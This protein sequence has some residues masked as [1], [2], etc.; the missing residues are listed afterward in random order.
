MRGIVLAATAIILGLAAR[1]ASAQG[2]EG[3]LV[4]RYHAAPGNT[5][6][7][8]PMVTYRIFLDLSPGHE[9]VSVFGERGRNL[10]FRT[11]TRF[12]NDTVNGAGGGERI[13]PELLRSYPAAIDSW[14]AFGFAT[15]RHKAVPLPLDQDGSL[16]APP[17]KRARGAW[18]GPE[19]HAADGLAPAARVPEVLLLHI[20][21]S[22]LEKLSGQLIETEVGAYGV[23]GTVK[24][25]TEENMVLIAQLTTDGELS[26][27]I[28]AAV[29]APDGTIT[30]HLA[31]PALASDEVEVP[32][33]RRGTAF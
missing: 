10:F 6:D 5:A 21:T 3:V 9:L 12:F 19:L 20:T 14:L 8:S 24:G 32:A 28:N 16:L 26:Y 11:T 25:A 23:R 15:D 18:Y 7:A 27:A 2:I 13:D 17:K 29:K 33:L 1:Q 4:E 30:K 31:Y 22:Y